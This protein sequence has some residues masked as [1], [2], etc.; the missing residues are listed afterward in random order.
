M[1]TILR[2]IALIVLVACGDLHAT[3]NYCGD[4]QN[5]YG[6]FD[7]RR[8]ADFT[9]S[10][11]LIEGAHFTADVENGVR[12]H[13]AT[14][15]GDLDYTL[16]AIPN[17][18]RALASLTRLALRDKAVQVVGMRY[19]VECWFNR[20][21]RFAPDD[22]AVYGAHASYLFSL[23]KKDKAF[24]LFRQAAA[25]EPDNPTINYNLGLAYFNKHDY[26][27]ARQYA[28]KA[29]AGGFPL[30]GLK[31]KLSALGEWDDATD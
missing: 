28:K 24:E 15:G 11:R 21:E 26:A 31:N 20:A 23:G 22:G 1:K 7:Y 29:Y 14:I 25:L 5:A 8:R 9:D 13:T 27:H 4:L 12:G 16:R 30:P 18:H 19:P 10:F 17:H 6:P 3:E 2:S